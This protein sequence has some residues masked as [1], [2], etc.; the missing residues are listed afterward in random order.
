MKLLL[1]PAM[2]RTQRYLLASGCSTYRQVRL[3]APR[4]ANP[5][6]HS[7]SPYPRDEPC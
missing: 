1:R 4:V 2:Y 6:I 7:T 3:H 5:T